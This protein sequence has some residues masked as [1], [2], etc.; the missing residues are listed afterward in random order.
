MAEASTT[1]LQ[2]WLD[3]MNGG[4]GAARNELLT[5]AEKRLRRLALK[6]F[7]G[8]LERWVEC[9]DVLQGAAVRLCRA[10]EAVRPPTVRRFF[11]LATEVIRRELIDLARHHF[12]KE[13]S[14][15][16][17]ATDGHGPRAGGEPQPPAEP[18]QSTLDPGRLAFWTEFH[19]RIEDL[20]EG[21]RA[22]FEL[23]WYQELPQAEV[24]QLLGVSVPTVKRRLAEAKVRLMDLL[25]GEGGAAEKVEEG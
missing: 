25:E 5:H 19:R 9:D 11:A 7:R 10:L 3:R 18:P 13:G 22:V 24:A 23:V 2:L 21:P 20:P 15:A 14:A 6:M 17:H 16:H 12:G 4:D 1:Q 8:R